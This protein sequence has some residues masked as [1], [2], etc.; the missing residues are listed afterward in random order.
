[1]VKFS[2]HKGK[3]KIKAEIPTSYSEFDIETLLK[4]HE[5]ILKGEADSRFYISL[6]SGVDYED[7]LSFPFDIIIQLTDAI[8]FIWE[9]EVVIVK[10]FRGLNY[11]EIGHL[12]YL[13]FEDWKVK[14]GQ[15]EDDTKL[16]PY[17]VSL[18]HSGE[19]KFEERDY[20][21]YLKLP[22]DI[23]IYCKN[24]YN[25]SFA[26]HQENY[27]PL[28]DGHEPDTQEEEAGYHQ[29]EK[30]G[31]YGTLSSLSGGDILKEQEIAKMKVDDVYVHLTYKKAENTYIKNYRKGLQDAIQ[32]GDRTV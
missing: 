30:W 7:L 25:K 6:L 28:Y 15:I 29:L 18:L 4:L 21:K 22:A 13:Q 12:Q 19:Y 14:Y 23:G 1:M 2:Y 27:R 32:R 8:R 31:Y 10:D 17:T 24:F 5:L 9:S 11:K 26:E 3:E 16:I 20:L